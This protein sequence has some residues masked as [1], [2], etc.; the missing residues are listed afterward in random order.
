MVAKHVGSLC[1][2]ILFMHGVENVLQSNVQMN[3][4]KMLANV[5]EVFA[6]LLQNSR[7]FFA[8]YH[9][10]LPHHCLQYKKFQ[11]IINTLHY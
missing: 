2:V 9:T 1:N 10:S 8:K 7:N 11:V 5:R 6:S 4:C 3:I